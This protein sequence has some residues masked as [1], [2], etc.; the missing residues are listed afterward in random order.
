MGTHVAANET[1]GA[2]WSSTPLG[3]ALFATITST[4]LLPGRHSAPRSVHVTGHPRDLAH[5]VRALRHG[6][7]A[8]DD[9]VSEI[10]VRAE[11]ACPE[12]V[13]G[14]KSGSAIVVRN[15]N[16]PEGASTTLDAVESHFDF[17]DAAKK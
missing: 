8:F 6:A 7:D 3:T 17:S 12:A 13:P 2:V 15:V 16:R 1:F 5:H 4:S 9:D 11:R 14:A 10:V